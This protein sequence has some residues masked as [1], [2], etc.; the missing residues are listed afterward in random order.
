MRS[1]SP[2][3]PS[4]DADECS[5]VAAERARLHRAGSTWPA[6]GRSFVLRILNLAAVAS[7]LVASGCM[8]W[9]TTNFVPPEAAFAPLPVTQN[10]PTLLAN[11]DRD[12]VFEGVV[13]VIDD[14][15]K[16]ARD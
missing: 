10:N 15:F 5:L 12:A 1:N 4:V 9:F 13:D 6:A 14:S 16:I 2:F 7:A 11:Q 3:R 8:S